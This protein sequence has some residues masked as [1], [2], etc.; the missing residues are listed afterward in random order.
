MQRFDL[1]DTGFTLV[2][3]LIS[4]TIISV[5]IVII[6]GSF[7]L[8]VRAVEKGES[9]LEKN[10]SYTSAI[11]LIKHQLNLLYASDIKDKKKYFLKGTVKEMDFISMYSLTNPYNKNL[12]KVKYRIEKSEKDINIL[13]IEEQ[14]LGIKNKKEAYVILTDMEKIAFDYLEA[15]KN[16]NKMVWTEN[17]NGDKKRAFPLAVRIKYFIEEGNMEIS[18]IS[19]IELT[20]NKPG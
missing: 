17:W 6:S 18:I 4:I 1:N 3:L 20:S 7:R 15:V 11:G 8:G 9:R 10:R 19:K 16:D 12:T 13:T 5:I 2:E 14:D